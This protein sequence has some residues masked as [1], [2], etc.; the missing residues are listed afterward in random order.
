MIELWI[1]ADGADAAGLQRHFER[2]GCRVL[3]RSAEGLRIGFPQA[4]SERE[5]LA[6]AR[7][8]LSMRRRG[9]SMF[10]PLA[11]AAAI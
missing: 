11:A 3:E 9:G 1:A 4:A 7:L 2:F 6:E 10:P 5:A 8:Y